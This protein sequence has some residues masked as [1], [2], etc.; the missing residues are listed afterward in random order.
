[1]QCIRLVILSLLLVCLAHS[2]IYS[3][4]PKTFYDFNGNP[5]Y[6]SIY[7]SLEYGIGASDYLRLIWPDQIYN[8]NKNEIKANLIDFS[9]NFQIA[10]TTFVTEP[11]AV[12]IL[13]VTFGY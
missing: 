2:H 5:K 9:N 6:Y 3:S 10:S 4:P 12:T 8:S 1:M 11:S 7:F 13:H